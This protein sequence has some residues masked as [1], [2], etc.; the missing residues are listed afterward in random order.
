MGI[1]LE[2]VPSVLG[3]SMEAAREAEFNVP[4]WAQTGEA[5]APEDNPLLLD[6]DVAGRADDVQRSEAATRSL[7]PD[8]LQASEHAHVQG[9]CEVA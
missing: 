4:A 6:V 1:P 5:A 7:Q 8:G 9:I 2:H 3:G